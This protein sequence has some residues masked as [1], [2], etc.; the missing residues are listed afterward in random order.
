MFGGTPDQ[1]IKVFSKIDDDGSGEITI[2]E[3][4]AFFKKMDAD[5]K[6]LLLM[7]SLIFTSFIMYMFL[8]CIINC[9]GSHPEMCN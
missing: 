3:I 5:G 6:N 1:A 7:P 9:S 2:D 8:T 4:N